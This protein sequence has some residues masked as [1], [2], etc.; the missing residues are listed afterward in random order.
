MRDP[1]SRARIVAAAV[2]AAACAALASIALAG[3]DGSDGGPDPSPI[4]SLPEP[5]APIP[6][7]EGQRKPDPPQ[8]IRWRQS[9]SLGTH[10][11]GRLVRGVRLPAEGLHFFTWDPILRRSPD[12]PWRRWGNDRLVRLVL[13]VLDD[14]ARAHPGAARV[15]VG[16]LSRPRGGDFGIRY[17]PP[18]HVSHENGLDADIYYPRVDRLERAPRTVGQVNRRLAQDLV[19]RFVRAGGQ[20]VFV[21]PSLGLR[22]P[23]RVVQAIPNH[24]NHLHVRLGGR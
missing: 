20:K 7:D 8:R 14:Y 12:R 3:S 9:R 16:D 5:A 18:G 11:A 22:G 4:T 23:R 2:A 1:S 15:G 24:D 17:G 10:T 19:D 21:G 6:G 13:R